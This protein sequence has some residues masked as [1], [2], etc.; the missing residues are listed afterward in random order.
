MVAVTIFSPLARS[1]RRGG[2]VGAVLA[3]LLIGIAVAGAQADGSSSLY[4]KLLTSAYPD[5]A[6]PSGFISA[7]VT[8]GALSSAA[9][10]YHA[11]GEVDVIVTGPDP[12]DLIAY[13]VYP[14]S[15]DAV[16]SLAHPAL[17]TSTAVGHI[18]GS[19]PGYASSSR[20]IAGAVTGK[21]ALGTTITNGF[22]IVAVREKDVIVEAFTDSAANENSGDVPN[23]L[24]LLKSAV[25]HWRLLAST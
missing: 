8:A 25:A 6:L 24:A 14:T 15:A 19:V 11:V 1:R 20:W 16:Q 22:T 21:N 17:R 2:I 7:Q 23:A 9:A 4:E 18:V 13:Q 5:S 10:H 12:D 3:V